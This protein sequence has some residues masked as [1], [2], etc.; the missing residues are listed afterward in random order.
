MSLPVRMTSGA[1]SPA[2]LNVV[3]L[4]LK[5]DARNDLHAIR[6]ALYAHLD[7]TLGRSGVMRN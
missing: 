2:L 4:M 7:R 5:E 3:V 1:R 6:N